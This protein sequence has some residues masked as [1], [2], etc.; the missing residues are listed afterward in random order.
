MKLD[1]K[2]I[3]QTVIDKN[4]YRL[5]KDDK[6]RDMPATEQT[7]FT[8]ILT[9]SCTQVGKKFQNLPHSRRLNRYGS[10]G[11]DVDLIGVDGEV[12]ETVK[13]SRHSSSEGNNYD[14]EARAFRFSSACDTVIVA[15]V[16]KENGARSNSEALMFLSKP[17]TIATISELRSS[18]FNEAEEK[19]VKGA[20]DSITMMWGDKEVA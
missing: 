11:I 13:G 6:N 2:K 5:M 20:M 14:R 7:M 19:R 15:M 16:L 4:N 18:V 3:A 12:V 9:F 1:M 10:T 17:M 8:D